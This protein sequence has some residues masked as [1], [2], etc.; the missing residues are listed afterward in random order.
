M[1]ICQTCLI[2]ST[3]P[4]TPFYF[5]SCGRCEDCGEIRECADAPSSWLAERARE[6]RANTSSGTH[7]AGSSPDEAVAKSV[8]EGLIDCPKC[9]QTASGQTGEY[10]CSVCGPLSRRRAAV[11]L[12]DLER[13][14]E[15]PPVPQCWIREMQDLRE[16][17]DRAETAYHDAKYRLDPET[18]KD[19]RALWRALDNRL[20]HLMHRFMPAILE[21]NARLI[22]ENAALARKGIELQRE[23]DALKLALDQAIAA[24]ELRL[25]SDGSALDSRRGLVGNSYGP[26]TKAIGSYLFDA[27]AYLRERGAEVTTDV[28]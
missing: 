26:K 5:A 6:Y 15:Q 7:G 11:T 3:G 24:T 9:E 1:F 10:P 22:S 12:S 18:E 21:E 20:W 13:L 8:E 23:R 28:A 14:E 27:E 2:E 17:V 25:S 4:E 16:D 19:K